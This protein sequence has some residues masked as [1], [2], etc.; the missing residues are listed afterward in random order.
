[1][2]ICTIILFIHSSVNEHL[3][4][5]HVLAVVN[6]AAVNIGVHVSFWIMFSSRHMPR[7]EIAGSCSS[8]SFSFLR[9][10]HTVLHGLP[11]WLGGKQSACQCRRC[12]FNPWV[13]KIPWRNK[14]QPTPV[15]L[16]GTSH[17]QR[18][19]AGCSPCGHKELDMADNAE[20]YLPLLF[21][22]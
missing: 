13:G 12:R 19:L 9:N 5:F 8:S 4:C 15:F 22:C 21:S 3:G 20:Q 18:G 7:S 11:R 14:W 6:S 10:L 17:G 2:H 1:M 16:S